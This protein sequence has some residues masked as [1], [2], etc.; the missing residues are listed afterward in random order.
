MN[1]T[2]WQ[3]QLKAGYFGE[4]NGKK[5]IILSGNRT[6]PNSTFVESIIIKD[7]LPQKGIYQYNCS[8]DST[9]IIL[10]GTP[11]IL[12]GWIVDGDQV[13]GISEVDT[14]QTEGFIE[15][16]KYDS[17]NHTIEGRFE[18][19]LKDRTATSPNPYYPI[20][21]HLTEGKFNLKI[22]Q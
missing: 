19:Y 10:N 8:C 5:L 20:N 22:E 21:I 16:I 3:G 1:G 4:F 13:I 17:I 18:A 7:I 11:K 15:V 14:A 6:I 2:E 12:M 9:A